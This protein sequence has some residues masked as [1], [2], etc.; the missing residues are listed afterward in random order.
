M[1]DD[2]QFSFDTSQT[3]HAAA[4]LGAL[5]LLGT[6]HRAL[7]DS[8]FTTGTW[9]Q[10]T[11]LLVAAST[12]AI[13]LVWTLIVILAALFI[14]VDQ[15]VSS[16][17]DPTTPA[18]TQGWQQC[19]AV[20]IYTPIIAIC[21]SIAFLVWA[22]LT[23]T[24]GLKAGELLWKYDP[25]NGYK[26]WFPNLKPLW[27]VV[28][29]G[30]ML[31]AGVGVI[32]GAA[33]VRTYT[34]CVLNIVGILVY[35][36]HAVGHNPYDQAVHRYRGRYKVI[37]WTDHNE[38][39][40]YLLP[41]GLCGGIG[42]VWHPKITSEFAIQAK[43][44]FPSLIALRAALTE[45]FHKGEMVA[46]RKHFMELQHA[47][48]KTVIE[49]YH[50]YV[51]PQD[52]IVK[53]AEWFCKANPPLD[54]SAVLLEKKTEC[55]DV[56]G[57]KSDRAKPDAAE[58]GEERGH[59]GA[60]LIPGA[61]DPHDLLQLAVMAR[62]TE[63]ESN[64]RASVQSG[65][66][67]LATGPAATATNVDRT[68][69][70]VPIGQ[71][72]HRVSGSRLST[73]TLVYESQ[74]GSLS[75]NVLHSNVADSSVLGE[76]ASTV[77]QINSMGAIAMQTKQTDQCLSKDLNFYHPL[78]SSILLLLV[79]AEYVLFANRNLFT[80]QKHLLEGFMKWRNQEL[81][82][83]EKV[84][85]ERVGRKGYLGL[86]ESLSG[87]CQLLPNV[88]MDPE[89]VLRGHFPHLKEDK[90]YEDALG[91]LWDATFENSETTIVALCTFFLA[92]EVMAQAKVNYTP[93]SVRAKTKDGTMNEWLALWRQGWYV[94]IL[95]QFVALSPAVVGAFI[96]GILSR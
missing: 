65:T 80:E 48:R 50:L 20:L 72:M 64:K 38:G 91:E 30:L 47:V 49:T 56:A 17:D 84:K 27:F 96:G 34:L 82:M 53:L 67:Q 14:P 24:R 37:L 75:R 85:V 94:A 66:Q 43:H 2:T 63:E 76:L 71:G 60:T 33:Q 81:G 36:L 4:S 42:A 5:T 89:N 52:D 6:V 86:V 25:H 15:S 61:K 3:L 8:G 54:D 19:M 58:H 51:M 44:Y 1:P 7:L 69:S 29:A 74:G 90:S 12:I 31:M 9:Q 40:A 92:W 46:L 93:L 88:P 62:D 35:A 11:D 22:T 16:T 77:I 79:H 28:T 21:H 10:S 45:G 59:I 18:C 73:S 57:D 68:R 95:A 41:T 83:A 78:S 23:Y 70:V 26:S 39:T 55:S 13:L 32:S 87:I